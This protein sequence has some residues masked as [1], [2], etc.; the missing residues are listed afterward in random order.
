MHTPEQ[1]KAALDFKQSAEELGSSLAEGLITAVDPFVL[2][3]LPDLEEILEQ[4]FGKCWEKV[5][6]ALRKHGAPQEAI[7]VYC[8]IAA[9]A[10]G[11]IS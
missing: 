9:D 6:N 3:G 4:T 5:G 11:G 1:V 8:D 10:M 7:D 2:G